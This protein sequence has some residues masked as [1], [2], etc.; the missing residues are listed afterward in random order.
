MVQQKAFGLSTGDC[1][2]VTAIHANIWPSS[3]D[4]TYPICE[5]MNAK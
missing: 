1:N 3:L 4:V 5:Y 2:H